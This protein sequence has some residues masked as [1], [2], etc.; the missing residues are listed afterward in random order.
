M[1]NEGGGDFATLQYVII[2]VDVAC[3]V[4]QGFIAG[5]DV[6][7]HRSHPTILIYEPDEPIT[8]GQTLAKIKWKQLLHK[9]CVIRTQF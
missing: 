6:I 1:I 4:K 3:H 8:E 2:R 5:K 7:Q 9:C